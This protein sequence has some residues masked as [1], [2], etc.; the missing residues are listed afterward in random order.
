MEQDGEKGKE[1][2]AAEREY[3]LDGK[4]I[5]SIDTMMVWSLE[6]LQ[7]IKA[8]HEKNKSLMGSFARFPSG[9]LGM[10]DTAGNLDFYDGNL[11]AIDS[12]GNI[13]LSDVVPMD[14]NHISPKQ[15]SAGLI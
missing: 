10:V 5:P 8:Y 3:F 9:H 11:R 4:E 2:G 14:I 7:F 1:K 12:E 13:T 15:L 6:V